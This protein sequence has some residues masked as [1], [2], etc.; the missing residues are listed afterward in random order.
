M[1]TL[2]SDTLLP[3]VVVVVVVPML[4]AES[5]DDESDDK[6]WWEGDKPIF[7]V[8]VVVGMVV[9]GVGVSGGTMVSDGVLW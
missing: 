9:V 1:P 5:D 7:D 2:P 8:L 4:L 6:E 3:P